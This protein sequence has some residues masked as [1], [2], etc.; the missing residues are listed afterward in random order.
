[1]PT[2]RPSILQNV[3][4]EMTMEV[5]LDVGDLAATPRGSIAESPASASSKSSDSLFDSICCRLYIFLL[6]LVSSGGY[7]FKVAKDRLLDYN[8]LFGFN[9]DLYHFEEDYSKM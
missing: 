8:L 3:V 9:N 6:V 2:A 1:M 5:H 4:E 7:H